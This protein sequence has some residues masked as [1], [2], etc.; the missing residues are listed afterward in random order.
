[1][2]PSEDFEFAVDLAYNYGNLALLDKDEKKAIE[3]FTKALTSERLRAD[4]HIALGDIY[5]RQ[6]KLGKAL[7]HYREARWIEP[8]NKNTLH[9]L[10]ILE[11]LL[12]NEN[13][14]IMRVSDAV[15]CG[16]SDSFPFLCEIYSET[17]NPLAALSIGDAYL[18]KG[19]SVE[20]RKYWTMAL[21]SKIPS[22]KTAAHF[23]IF[24]TTFLD[25][26]IG[27]SIKLGQRALQ[28]GET[29]FVEYLQ[30]LAHIQGTS[31]DDHNK[32]LRAKQV[33][34]KLKIPLKKPDKP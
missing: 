6:D 11:Y 34:E 30:T 26:D 23:K 13:L 5:K 28:E 18:Q 8:Q 10:G 29:D 14:A 15:Q 9:N 16:K 19:N 32:K 17:Q 25:G 3:L 1:M 22:V 24:L 27:N 4:A 33:L 21:V 12:G 31:S 20:A 7:E 2:S